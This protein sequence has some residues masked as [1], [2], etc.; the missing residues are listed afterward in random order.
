MRDM[1]EL[2]TGAWVTQSVGVAAR[3]GLADRLAEHPLS[4][5]ELAEAVGAHPARLGRLL[6]ML[7]GHGV[8]RVDPDGRYRLTARGE[9]LRTDV[10]GSLNALAAI[11][12]GL[13]FESYL[14]LEHAVR[15]GEDAFSHVHGADSFDYF[16][17]HPKVARLFERA[18]AFGAV[19]F[20]AVPHVLDLPAKAVVVDIGGGS[21]ELLSR[22]LRAAPD[23]HG[24]LFERA[25]VVDAA[26]ETLTGAGC[27]DRYEPIVGD[28]FVDPLPADGD[29][30]L[31]SRILHDWEDGECAKILG[32]L[33]EV[34]PA[35]ATLAIVERPVVEAGGST[36]PLR[37]DIQM[38]TNAR[39]RERSVDEYRSLL[40]TAG[41]ALT[42]VRPLPLDM[43]V[44]TARRR[45]TDRPDSRP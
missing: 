9:L 14:G 34:V 39:G 30:Y 20:D 21:G 3:L 41:F 36:L 40:S 16:A 44:L 24:V 45:P 26:A 35:D 18:M 37:Y 5:P 31:L 4:A 17:A 42:D 1:L 38:M 8:L 33:A 28:F 15:T 22:V 29:L 19:V 7:A 2:V 12:S 13:F 25:H 43:A 23:A 6:R 32:R 11:Y 10:D 27:A